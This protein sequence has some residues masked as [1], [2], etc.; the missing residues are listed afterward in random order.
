MLFLLTCI[1]VQI[2]GEL[3]Y[4]FGSIKIIIIV[5]TILLMLIIDTMTREAPEWTYSRYNTPL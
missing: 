3:E 1:L 5:M 2:Y 4:L